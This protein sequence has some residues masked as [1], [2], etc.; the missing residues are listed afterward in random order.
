MITCFVHKVLPPTN[1]KMALPTGTLIH[2]FNGLI[3]IEKVVPGT[4]L[5]TSSGLSMTEGIVFEGKKEVF[6]MRTELGTF[7]CN[8][9]SDLVWIDHEVKGGQ[10]VETPWLLGYLHGSSFKSNEFFDAGDFSQRLIRDINQYTIPKTAGNMIM[11]EHDF[12]SNCVP[13]AVLAGSIFTRE[14]YAK[15][16]LTSGYDKVSDIFLKQIQ[17]IYAS[18]GIKS[19]V[20]PGLFSFY[21]GSV[22]VKEVLKTEKVCDMWSIPGECI[23]EGFLIRTRCVTGDTRIQTRT[24]CPQ[25]SLVV[26]EL[27]EIWNGSKW[28]P[29]TPT[30][31]GTSYIYRVTLS[32]GSYLD[33][34]GSHKWVVERSKCFSLHT[35]VE[36]S[37]LVIGDILPSFSL[38]EITGQHDLNVNKF[39]EGAYFLDKSSIQVLLLR[40]SKQ[41]TEEVARGLQILLRRINMM[42]NIFQNP[43][44]T[45]SLG[46]NKSPQKVVS[47]VLLDGLYKVYSMGKGVYNNCLTG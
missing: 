25:I 40:T 42:T 17:C 43:N 39:S 32:D 2:T 11:F 29:V 31:S 35:K 33:C 19:K 44:G 24:G 36:T 8:G 1:N 41:V 47:I 10:E 30:V 20:T 3:P 18:L 6:T 22:T 26:N 21:D 5:Y 15:G 46:Y 27:V 23:A 12:E 38:G 45:W 28:S 4:L 14:E 34:T 37:K 13:Q 9:C 16:F 7:E